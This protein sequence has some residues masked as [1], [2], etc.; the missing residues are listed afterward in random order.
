MAYKRMTEGER[1]LIYRWIQEKIKKQRKSRSTGLAA[2]LC[3]AT[4]T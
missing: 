2:P 4:S 3:Y 1:R